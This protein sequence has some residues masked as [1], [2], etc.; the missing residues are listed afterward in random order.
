MSIAYANPIKQLIYIYINFQN[1][2]SNKQ[3][4]KMELTAELSKSENCLSAKRKSID[5]PDSARE[6]LTPPPVPPLPVNYQLQRSDGTF[7]NCTV[8]YNIYTKCHLCW[9]MI[10]IIYSVSFA[11]STDESYLSN[12]NREQ[13]KLRAYYKAT[14]QAELKR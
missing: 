10:L 13:K 4:E 1:N 2:K 7:T 11:I 8:Y 3:K 6:E 12:D 5:Q 14:R 9:Q